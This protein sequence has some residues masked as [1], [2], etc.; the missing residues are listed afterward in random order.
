M[1][2]KKGASKKEKRII[3]ELLEEEELLLDELIP[4]KKTKK[5]KKKDVSF[6]KGLASEAEKEYTDDDQKFVE[7]LLTRI[8]AP[9]K[10]R[11][12]Q[13]QINDDLIDKGIDRTHK[14][15]LQKAFDKYPRV[16]RLRILKFI[17]LTILAG[18]IFSYLLVNTSLIISNGNISNY[19]PIVPVNLS[20][21]S[22]L[23]EQIVEKP[24][25]REI[26]ETDNL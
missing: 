18:I 6:F 16:H 7:R 21:D 4:K 9:K 11:L 24:C 20:I 23:A 10:K 22:I 19:T 25:I 17:V 12:T 15:A 14:Q 2:R 5:H 8:P 3:R 26:V 1:S 13:K